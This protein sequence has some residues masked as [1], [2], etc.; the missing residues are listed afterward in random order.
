MNNE[1]Q[2]LQYKVPW[3][4]ALMDTDERDLTRSWEYTKYLLSIVTNMIRYENIEKT[5]IP[6]YYPEYVAAYRGQ[7]GVFPSDDGLVIVPGAYCGKLDK[8]GHGVEYQG[9]TLDGVDWRGKVGTDCFVVPNNPMLMPD[10]LIIS[11]FVFM[12]SQTD[13]SEYYN[14]K[15]SRLGKFY[16]A[17]TDQEKAA[18]EKAMSEMEAG[19]PLIYVGTPRKPFGDVLDGSEAPLTPLE[20][21]DVN[22]SEKLQYLSRF[23]DDIIGR[24]MAMYGIDT[25]NINKGSQ[26]L[27]GELSRMEEAAAVPVY[28]RLRCRAQVWDEINKAFG[29]DIKP[30][31][32]ALY[33]DTP[34]AGT[35]Q[36][37]IVEPEGADADQSEDENK[38]DQSEDESEDNSNE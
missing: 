21:T 15:Y 24:F 23:H 35:Q 1:Y 16:R 31:K 22:D 17:D 30:V 38:D 28:E 36:T 10:M 4:F 20:L 6:E 7:Y 11:R 25:G 18:L 32:S 13:I 26:V 29:T 33:G 34:E 37:D 5:D 3:S 12:L 14:L 2:R 27:R 8:Y 19:K 9:T